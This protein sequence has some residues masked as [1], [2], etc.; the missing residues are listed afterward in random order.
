MTEQKTVAEE[1]ASLLGPSGR[2][3]KRRT[4]NR[5]VTKLYK[6]YLAD[7]SMC[8]P[9]KALIHIQREFGRFCNENQTWASKYAVLSRLHPNLLEKLDVW[10]GGLC[11]TTTT[12]MRLAA[13]PV[14]WQEEIWR[15]A[16]VVAR[17]KQTMVYTLVDLMGRELRD[18]DELPL[19]FSVEL[20]QSP[21]LASKTTPTQ[22]PAPTPT[23]TPAPTTAPAPVPKSVAAP[24]PRA[25]DDE[26]FLKI[27]AK[28]N[29]YE[30]RSRANDIAP[31]KEPYQWRGDRN[32]HKGGSY[33]N[34]KDDSQDE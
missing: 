4:P 22:K 16:Q 14:E 5:E 1:I 6:R 9:E 13:R 2:F 17:G 12:A 28:T 11:L 8:K 30:R 7:E 29:I 21:S 27:L 34:S 26:T 23:P 18:K 32:I 10:D 20:I 19:F 25:V 31:S 3:V 24:D 33:G 15:R